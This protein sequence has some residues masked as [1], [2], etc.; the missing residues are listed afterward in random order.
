MKIA[1][2]VSR[3][4]LGLILVLAGASGFFIINNPPP[5]PPGMATTF[6]N[7]FF[8]SRWVLFVDGMEFITGALL[9]ANRYVPLALL[10]SA[11]II[12]NMYVFH[13]TMMPIGVFGPL[14]LTILWIVVAR[15]HR[16][17]LE[18]LLAADA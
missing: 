9:L 15:Q 13:I 7:I 18:P 8:E 12:F 10:A 14:V 16:A 4:V 17:V 11:A 2:L 1:T 3:I 5:A 6:M